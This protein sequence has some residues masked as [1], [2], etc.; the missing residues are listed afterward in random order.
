[1]QSLWPRH[2]NSRCPTWV[3]HFPPLLTEQSFRRHGTPCPVDQDENDYPGAWP[4]RLH[5]LV[6][7]ARFICA[8]GLYS[9]KQWGAAAA[10]SGTSPLLLWP[11]CSNPCL[12]S[13][14]V[15][16]PYI[17]LIGA[18]HIPYGLSPG[19]ELRPGVGRILAQCSSKV[20]NRQGKERA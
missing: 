6:P 9:T 19:T 11:W 4:G 12:T 2:P 16:C 5:L 1:M 13:S 15:C 7:K 20:H 10:E 14:W 18:H 3:I 8:L 17:N